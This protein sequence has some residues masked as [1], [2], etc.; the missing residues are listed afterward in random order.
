MNVKYHRFFGGL[1]TTQA[2]W[3]NQMAGKGYRLVR[4]GKLLY[5]FEPCT[6][7]QYQYQVEYIAQKPK[8]SAQDYAAF[9]EDC[10]YRVWFKNLNLDYSIGKVALRPWAEKGARISTT[11]T[12][13]NRELLIVEKESDGKPFQLHTTWEDRM[14]YC[15][16]LRRPWLFLLLLFGILGIAVRGLVWWIFA[17]AALA[18][19]AAYQIELEKIKKQSILEEGS[20]MKGMPKSKKEAVFIVLAV[21]AVIA[22]SNLLGLH[23][24]RSATRLGY[25]G[26]ELPRSWSGQY[27]MLDG[28]MAH[29][30]SPKDPPKTLRAEIVTEAGIL[31]IL[32][33]DRDGNVLLDRE[34]VGTDS[35]TLPVDG[36][37]RVELTAEK[38]RGRFDIR[39]E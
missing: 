1:L 4:T 11:A 5:E 16:A 25:F 26:N 35:I 36:K 38:H 15:K 37:V 29:T 31:S 20:T 39:I 13:L 34:N 21:V 24:T 7:G 23:S 28:T 18:G 3:L 32:I 2:N 22:V 14:A 33:Y 27:A 9:L 17:A 10:G 6:P 8:Q 30:L 12:T 19:V